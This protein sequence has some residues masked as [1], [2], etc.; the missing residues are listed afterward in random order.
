MTVDASVWTSPHFGVH[1][2]FTGS[3]NANVSDSFNNT[4]N[5]SA[6]EQWFSAGARARSFFGDG[7]L[8]PT[9]QFGVDYREDEFR[10]PSD[11]VF[12][13]KLTTSGL[14]LLIDAEFPTS[15]L[16]SWILGGEFGP[17]LF[18][19]ESSNATEFRTGDDPQATTVGVHF[20]ASYR[21]D[22]AQR[23]FWKIS[24][25]VERDLFSGPTTINDPLTGLPQTN[26]S[27]TNSVTLFQLGYI[28]G[29]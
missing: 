7:P 29:N 2:G 3:L 18:H 20:G 4:K 5:A 9:L 17:K 11:T 12:R 15:G 23:L 26:V 6:S 1:T 27:V 13:N 14:H 25:G 22:H 21:F 16:G 24:H 8:A 28:W 10:V 19:R